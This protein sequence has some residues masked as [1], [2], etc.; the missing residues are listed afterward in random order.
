MFTQ[1]TRSL[2]TTLNY[3]IL[4][5]IAYKVNFIYN[6][7]KKIFDFDVYSYIYILDIVKII[8]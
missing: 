6:I 1:K 4:N 7:K 5:H 3:L 8:H 2:I